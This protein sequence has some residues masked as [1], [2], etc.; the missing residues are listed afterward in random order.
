MKVL[1]FP[2][3]YPHFS[4]PQGG[5]FIRN[6]AL[7]V[8]NLGVQVGVCYAEPRSLRN[9]SLTALSQQ[10]FQIESENDDGLITIRQKGWNTLLNSSLG[11]SIWCRQ[12]VHLA[13]KYIEANGIPDLIHAH[14]T[15]WAGVAAELVSSKFG[16]PFLITEHSSKLMLGQTS[17]IEKTSLVRALKRANTVVAVSPNLAKCLQ[18]HYL[19]REISIIPNSVDFHKFAI[20]DEA[21]LHDRYQFICV[22]PFDN[23]KRQ[24]VLIEAFAE[25]LPVHRDTQLVLVGDGSEYRRLRIMVSDRGLTDNVTFLPFMAQKDLS[26]LLQRCDCLVSASKTE[27]FGL[28]IVEALATGLPVI[29][30]RSGGPENIVV[31]A[32][33]LLVDADSPH[34]LAEAMMKFRANPPPIRSEIRNYA[35]SRFSS[36]LVA[37]Q[38]VKLYRAMVST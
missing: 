25:V 7:A 32:V 36:T 6:Q 20:G 13:G 9:F 2:F 38:L 34:E 29:A 12:M 11:A 21:E 16:I 4:A 5:I 33:G 28:S 8:A 23:N 24:A 31:P 18:N 19:R 3:I 37:E 10:H 35:M 15:L 1:L 22:G 14:G 26:K 30:T 27:T 17:L